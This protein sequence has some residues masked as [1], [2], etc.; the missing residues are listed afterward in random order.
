MT[1]SQIVDAYRATTGMVLTAVMVR[2]DIALLQAV[3]GL[4][5]SIQSKY[6]LPRF[7]ASSVGEGAIP[8]TLGAI[9]ARA[10]SNIV[11]PNDMAPDGVGANWRVL[12]YPMSIRNWSG[13]LPTWLQDPVMALR[14]QSIVDQ[15]RPVMAL[16]FKS[17]LADQ[18]RLIKECEA[19][20]ARWDT[21]DRVFTGIATFGASELIAVAKTK[22]QAAKD[23]V[24]EYQTLRTQA[25]SYL[26]DP[27]C[28]AEVKKQIADSMKY[29][30]LLGLLVG[31]KVSAADA[32][33]ALAGETV[34]PAQAAELQAALSK[35]PADAQGMGLDMGAVWAAGQAD[36]ERGLGFAPLA[37]L[38]AIPVGTM[39]CIAI[40]VAIVAGLAIYLL[41][42][43]LR[44]AG[45]AME[46]LAKATGKV[47]ETLG[48]PGLVAVLAL[49]GLGYYFYKNPGQWGQLKS[50]L[51][52]K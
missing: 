40:V 24:A 47:V 33:A 31:G 17:A 14:W 50:K 51:H 12:L 45:V 44:A 48:G 28:P 29:D 10:W 30:N 5:Q 13:P 18:A 23:K 1:Y 35:T 4:M 20:V 26:N 43:A 41:G 25:Q 27:K 2:N 15:T 42:P 32:S 11:I 52:L 36:A 22:V 9:V 3:N 34:D 46:A 39:V 49:G 19:S 8:L 38:A 7:D 16:V 37:A 6:Q 21:A